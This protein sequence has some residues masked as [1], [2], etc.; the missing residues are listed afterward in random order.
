MR[1]KNL[2]IVGW[3][4]RLFFS[5]MALKTGSQEKLTLGQQYGGVML[6]GDPLYGEYLDERI[7]KLTVAID[8]LMRAKNEAQRATAEEMQEIRTALTEKRRTI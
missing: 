3:D 7:M 5:R 6:D 4:A 1:L 8:G 2:E